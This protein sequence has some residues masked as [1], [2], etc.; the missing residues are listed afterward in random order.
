MVVGS[1]SILERGRGQ[2]ETMDFNQH[3]VWKKATLTAPILKSNNLDLL[4]IS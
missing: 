3:S 4:Y 1:I 2:Q